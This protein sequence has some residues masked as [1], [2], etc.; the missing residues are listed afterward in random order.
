MSNENTQSA[1]LTK[2]ETIEIFQK[3]VNCKALRL[4]NI[5]AHQL[6]GPGVWL[7]Q[8][9]SASSLKVFDPA[10]AV[11]VPYASLPMFFVDKSLLQERIDPTKE[12][13]VA[14]T[15]IISGENTL[16]Y[17]WTKG[18]VNDNNS[19]NSTSKKE[20]PKSNRV[21]SSSDE[22]ATSSTNSPRVNI[23]QVATVNSIR[24]P[25]TPI[26]QMKK[27]NGV[28]ID[29]KPPVSGKVQSSSK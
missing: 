19:T 13:L 8:A 25:S 16:S 15:Y 20:V 1:R 6:F 4:R 11:Y 24:K 29:G 21:Q 14:A 22:K 18:S 28:V 3:M 12:I 7:L 17:I 23:P 2:D 27:T 10:K 5:S 9:K 26:R